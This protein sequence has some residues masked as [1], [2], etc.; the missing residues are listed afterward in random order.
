MGIKTG[1]LTNADGSHRAWMV[2]CPACGCPHAFDAR[3]TFNGDHE[4]PTF[5]GSMLV[6]QAIENPK[7]GLLERTG[8]SECHSHL[9]DGVWNYLS[10]CQHALRG[11]QVPAPDWDK[12][13]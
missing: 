6:R 2:Q 7:T 9:V 4:R 11:Q 13:S 5:G 10:D 3:W 12:A 1:Q 8:P